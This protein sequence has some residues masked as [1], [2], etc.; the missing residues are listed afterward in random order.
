MED[1]VANLL[2]A[3]QNSRPVGV[4]RSI[5]ELG[6]SIIEVNGFFA[7]SNIQTLLSIVNIYSEKEEGGLQVSYSS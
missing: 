7:S 3:N 6:R 1:K 5:K 4:T 2:F